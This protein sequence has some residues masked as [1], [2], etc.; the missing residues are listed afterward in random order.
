MEKLVTCKICGK[1]SKRIYG[2]HLSSHGLTSEQYLEKYPN[3]KLYCDSDYEKTTKNS[4]KHMKEDKYKKMFSEKIKGKNNPNH[5]SKTTEEERR[6]RSPFSTEFI[7]YDNVEERN[8]F[9]K[10]VNDNK[11]PESYNTKIEYW[12]SKGYNYEEAKIKLSERQITFSLEKCIE[13]HGKIEGERIFNERQLKWRN[14]LTTNGNLKMGYSKISQ[15]LFYN[16][17]EYYDFNH[18]KHIQFATKNKEFI[19]PKINGGV[20]V[21]DFTDSKNKKIIEY[22]GDQYHGN[23]NLYESDDYPQPFRKD[24]T[25]GEIWEKDERKIKVAKDRGFDV[26]VIWDS[27]YKSRPEFT[28]NKCLDF[29]GINK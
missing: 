3:S 9:V 17:L 18:H 25:A 15:K 26:L 20:W 27:E 21:Y 6:S 2:R 12:L 24:Y 16:I 5:K 13:R 11:T 23:P 8:D 7:K 19:L 22:N 28:L 14:S 4:G 10:M 1:Q 29:L